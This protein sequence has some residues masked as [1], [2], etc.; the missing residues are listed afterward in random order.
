MGLHLSVLLLVM[1]LA[2]NKYYCH[3][4]KIPHCMKEHISPVRKPTVAPT[5]VY[6]SRNHEEILM[7]LRFSKNSKERH[8]I[9]FCTVWHWPVNKE[10][11]KNHCR[12]SIHGSSFVLGIVWS[13][14]YCS[15]LSWGPA[16]SG[17]STYS[18]QAHITESQNRLGWETPFRLTPSTQLHAKEI[19]LI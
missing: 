11:K 16:I 19:S 4:S 2:G 17:T 15:S 8:F 10:E 9:P 7:V 14:I 13:S 12:V 3:S 1:I 5:W 18:Q 6:L